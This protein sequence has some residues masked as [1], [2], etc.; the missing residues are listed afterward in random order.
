MPVKTVLLL[1]D[2]STVMSLLRLILRDYNL[3][4]TTSAEE[5]LRQFSQHQR[6]IDLLIADVTLPIDSGVRLALLLRDM[7]SDLSIVLT[8]GCP[9]NVWNDQDIGDLRRIGSRSVAFLQK[10]FLPAELLKIVDRLLQPPSAITQGPCAV[11]A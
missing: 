10:P 8:S 5:A 9:Q 6:N 11:R 4:E 1:E 7:S 3:V 2:N